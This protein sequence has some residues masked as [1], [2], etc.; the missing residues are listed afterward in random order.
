[1][2]HKKFVAGMLIVMSF[3]GFVAVQVNAFSIKEILGLG[4][5]EDGLAANE[6]ASRT[7]TGGQPVKSTGFNPGKPINLL[8]AA[9]VNFSD[10]QRILANLDVNQRTALLTSQE[11][12]QN[13]INQ[14]ANNLSVLTAAI[15][16]KM[17]ENVNTRFLMQR[18]AQSILRESYVGD[19]INSKLPADFPTD[20]QVKEYYE[21]NESQ[22]V[23][24]ERVHVWQ[25][26]LSTE[27]A[28]EAAQAQ[29][30]KQAERI[31]R[32]LASGEL[33]FD[34]AVKQYSEHA[35]SKVNGGYMGLLSVSELKPALRESILNLSEGKTSQAVQGD[36][37][38]HIFKRGARLVEQDVAFDQINAQIRQLLIKQARAQLRKAI[39]EQAQ[40]TYPQT[41]TELTVEEWRLRLSTGAQSSNT[42]TTAAE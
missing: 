42:E 18:G 34:A 1:M 10:I 15:S 28:D 22:F 21:Q 9:G 8:S 35:Q 16:D 5:G 36:A 31:A 13:F 2:K 38:F 20:E 30:R 37:G 40:E 14:E 33:D 4:E 17:D 3:A 19:L 26:F 12:F 24:G 11:A 23:I 7:A 39:F 41:L 25:V 6:K 32:E 27:G 29:I